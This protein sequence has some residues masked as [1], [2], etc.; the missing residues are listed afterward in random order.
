[1]S[2]QRR[3]AAIAMADDDRDVFLWSQPVCRVA[4]VGPGGRPH[5]SALWFV[6]DG[7]TIWLNSLVRSQRWADIARHPQVSVI[8]DDGGADFATLRGVELRCLAEVVGEAPRTGVPVAAL[9]GPERLFAGK[10][11][12]GGPFRYDGRHAW[13]RLTPNKIVSWDFARLRPRG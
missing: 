6:W 10:Y 7:A 1:M 4:T 3:G 9:D 8:V 11:A 5:I 2:G 13:L 12:G